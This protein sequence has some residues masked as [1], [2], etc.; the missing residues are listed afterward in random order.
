MTGRP[1]TIAVLMCTYRRDAVTAALAALGRLTAPAGTMLRIV[2]IDNDDTAA[3]AGIIAGVPSR[4]P[5]AYVHAPAGNI[6]RARNAGLDRADRMSAAWVAFC[7]DDEIMPPDWIV[8]LHGA[9][10]RADVVI[11]PVRAIYPPGAPPWMVTL[12]THGTPARLRAAATLQTGHTCNALLRWSGTPWQRLRFDEALG[13]SGG[14]DTAFFFAVSRRGGTFV[15][16]PAACVTEAVDPG[17]LSVRW[18]L[19][20][21]FRMG[22]SFAMGQP[23]GARRLA[24]AMTAS[25]KAMAC[26]AGAIATLPWTHRRMFWVLRAALHLGVVAGCLRLPQ[27]TLYGST[28]VP[29]IG[30]ALP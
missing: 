13:R 30:R 21:R 6:S 7:D 11:G 1:A 25:A 23:A 20:R 16:S 5:V 15:T 24:L 22:Q 4:W 29:P 18:L 9:A 2:V 12:D 27:P 8:A 3:K 28:A 14:E 17:R 10:G 19:K 26:A